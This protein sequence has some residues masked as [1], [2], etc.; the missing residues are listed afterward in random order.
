MALPKNWEAIAAY[1]MAHGYTPIATAG[2]L[3]NIE[4]ESGGDPEAVGTGGGGLIGFTPLPAG[5]VTGNAQ[6]DL[7]TQLA[8]LIRYNNAQGQLLIAQLNRSRTAEQAAL[9]YQ[10][11]FERPLPGPTENTANRVNSAKEVY[12][13]LA[14]SQGVNPLNLS[15]D[16]YNLLT[17]GWQFSAPTTQD[18]AKGSGAVA[19]G[20][21]FNLANIGKYILAAGL[22]GVGVYFLGR[23]EN[24]IPAPSNVAKGAAKTA[25]VVA[26]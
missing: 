1:L 2:I 6:R 8:G 15:N 4:Q 10:N 20:L 14:G 23:R 12:G 17:G 7:Q 24:V 25:A 3:G 18:L 13:K 5:Y 9:L 11:N 22:V 19:K 26:K 16:V 21:D